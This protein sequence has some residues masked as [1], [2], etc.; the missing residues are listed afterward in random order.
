[1]TRLSAIALSLAIL[2]SSQ[3][4]RAQSQAQMNAQAANE[5]RRADAALNAQWKQT[6]ARM[7]DRDARGTPRGGGFGYATAT[8][9]SQRAWLQFRDRQ[10]EIEGGE[11]AGGSLQGFARAQCLARLTRERTKQLKDLM[12]TR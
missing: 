12:W 11:Y 7:K 6:Y 10:C 9:A 5:L 8:L 3:P 4:A 1:M 2:A